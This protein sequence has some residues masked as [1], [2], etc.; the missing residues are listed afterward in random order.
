MSGRALEREA[1]ELGRPARAGAA[2]DRAV[3]RRS[4]AA[5]AKGA[6]RSQPLARA[7]RNPRDSRAAGLGR[8]GAPARARRRFHGRHCGRVEVIG[9]ELGAD[10]GGGAAAGVVLLPSDR[11]L[12]VFAELG[13]VQTPRSRAC[14]A[15]RA[16]ASSGAPA[17]AA[18]APVAQRLA[19]AP[20]LERRRARELRAAIASGWPSRAACW[21]SRGAASGRAYARRRRGRQ[22]RH[23]P[24]RAR[25]PAEGVAVIWVASELEELSLGSA[26][27]CSCSRAGERAASSNAARRTPTRC[28]A[29]R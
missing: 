29:P 26:T 28:C 18:V 9:R 14:G 13:V 15:S 19:L 24:L 20:V 12:S 7:R 21:P 3:P 11:A 27:A 6:V 22:G 1:Q 17:K 16:S 5:G 23:L 10:A 2:R 4:T 25:A 8:L